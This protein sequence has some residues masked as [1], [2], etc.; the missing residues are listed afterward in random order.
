M[1]VHTAQWSTEKPPL[2]SQINWGHSLSQGLVGCWILNEGGG[3]LSKNI[4]PTPN[5]NLALTTNIYFKNNYIHSDSL[6]SAN[7]PITANTFKITSTLSCFASV[8]RKGF[9]ASNRQVMLNRVTNDELWFLFNAAANGSETL[10]IYLGRT[11]TPGYHKSTTAFNQVGKIYQVGFTYDLSNVRIY[12]DG[13]LDK[14]SPDTGNANFSAQTT[15]FCNGSTNQYPNFYGDFFYIYLW[16]RALSLSEI[17]S[18]YVEPYRM[19]QP[20]R[21]R[22]Y[23]PVSEEAPAVAA[24]IMTTRT[25]FWGDL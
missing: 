5:T 25:N 17:Q 12:A 22:F 1:F 16:N 9:Y 11:N 7:I 23:F 3:K 14:T 2:G 13:K 24:G 21:R 20:I 6:V 19:I 15:Y 8:R 10:D 18:L 4:A